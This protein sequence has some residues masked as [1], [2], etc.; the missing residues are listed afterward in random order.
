MIKYHVYNIY[1]LSK[2]WEVKSQKEKSTKNNKEGVKQPQIH[3]PMVTLTG[4]AWLPHQE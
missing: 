4:C 3:A 2:Y 1:I